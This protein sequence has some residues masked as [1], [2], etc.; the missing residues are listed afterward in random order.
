MS[1]KRSYRSQYSLA[2]VLKSE[3]RNVAICSSNWL[4]LSPVIHLIVIY[5]T[6]VPHMNYYDN[7]TTL[8]TDTQ[9]IYLSHEH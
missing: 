5:Q 9:N 8:R 4:P 7:Y 1:I 6:A 2:E 3:C